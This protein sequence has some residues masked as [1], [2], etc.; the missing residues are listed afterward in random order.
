MDSP[1]PLL[2]LIISKFF[3]LPWIYPDYCGEDQQVWLELPHLPVFKISQWGYKKVT[4]VSGELKVTIGKQRLF[5]RWNEYGKFMVS[6]PSGRENF[7]GCALPPPPEFTA[8]G[9]IGRGR[10]KEGQSARPCPSVIPRH[11]AR[12]AQKPSPTLWADKTTI[13]GSNKKPGQK[14]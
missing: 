3:S 14:N 12:V 11:G 7:G 9:G 6:L 2:R 4:G 8:R 10:K 13:P 1:S 5:F